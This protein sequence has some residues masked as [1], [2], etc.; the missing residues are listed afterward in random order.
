[1]DRI[2]DGRDETGNCARYG[3]KLETSLATSVFKVPY[4]LEI[5]YHMKEGAIS[6]NINEGA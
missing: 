1:M 2:W 3:P 5:L 6:M 4:T